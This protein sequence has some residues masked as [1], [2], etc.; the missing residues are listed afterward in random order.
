MDSPEEAFPAYSISLNELSRHHNY[1]LA[2]WARFMQH[3]KVHRFCFFACLFVCL[4]VVFGFFILYLLLVLC[5]DKLSFSH[6][7]HHHHPKKKARCLSCPIKSVP[8]RFLF[9]CFS[10]ACSKVDCLAYKTLV[11]VTQLNSQSLCYS[12]LCQK[13]NKKTCSTHFFA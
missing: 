1:S 2:F 12:R 10:R 5:F 13:T 9:C 4:G 3:I 7:H 11:W 6:H 8:L